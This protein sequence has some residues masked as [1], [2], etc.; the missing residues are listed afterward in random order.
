MAGGQ[1]QSHRSGPD[2][3]RSALDFVHGLLC[4]APAQDVCLDELLTNL[5]AAFAAS[6]AGLAA[7]SSGKVLAR[8]PA[9]D[10]RTP[11]EE[12]E[13]VMRRAQQSPSALS[14]SRQSAGPLLLTAVRPHAHSGWMLWLE[15]DGERRA[16]TDA[17]AAALALAGQALG[18]ILEA[19][20]SAARWAE[21]LDRAERQKDLETAARVAS[22]L[23]HD[24]GNVLTGIIGFCD[25]SL[26]LKAPPESQLSR[27]LRELQ[28]CAQNGAELTHLLRLFCRRQVGG[29]HPC[30]TKAV[31]AEEA[32]RQTPPGGLFAVRT[33]FGDDLPQ[34]GIDAGQLRQIL[35]VLLEN[36]RDAMQG[37][38][39][40]S[41]SGRVVDLS[42]EDCL[43]LYGDARPGSYVEIAV[44]DS[45]P[46]LSPDVAK[47][48]FAELFFT[49]KPRRRGFGLAVAYG[50]LHAH[51]GGLR[52]RPAASGGTIAEMY[53]PVAELPIPAV[54]VAQQAGKGDRIL[55][56]DDD[57]SI[58]RMIC[59]TLERAGYRVQAATSAEEALTCYATAAQDRFDLV[60]SDLAMPR[61]TGVDLA[62][63][64]L[65]RD[66]HVRVLF[67]SGQTPGESIRPDSI[68]KGFSFLSK[69]FRPDGLLRAVRGAIDCQPH[70]RSVSDEA[71]AVRPSLSL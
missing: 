48:I 55:V 70:S 46:G 22:R 58:L 1:E 57:K 65:S 29:V 60:L 17:E 44:T 20:A 54:P 37:A 61:L 23:A 26:A 25:L 69:P 8:R 33:T 39:A 66:A 63:R 56:V 19:P 10:E 51:R 34:V 47:R 62:R 49:N 71:G 40:V 52:L 12:D 18:R 68:A 43:N 42:A 15:A 53:V 35:A 31:V 13:Q 21:Q 28:R 4:Q 30:E 11:W 50:V 14:I 5:A 59:A 24:F 67:M 3:S 36:A 9:G 6:G 45:G 16:W 7:L 32:V 38:G 2:A 64:L 27:Y 41:V